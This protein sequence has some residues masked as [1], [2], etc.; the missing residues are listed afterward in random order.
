MTKRSIV[1]GLLGAAF[2]C[3]A[4]YFND[5]VMR[6]TMLIGNSLPVAVYGGL[7]LFLLLVNP[8][9]RRT[10]L[11]R[12]FSGK[13]L[14]VALALTLAA[15]AIPGSGLMRTFTSTLMLPHHFARTEAGWRDQGVMDMTPA[16]MLADVSG[17]DGDTALSGFIQGMGIGGSHIA[18]RDI[19]WQAW[20][21]TLGF[22]LPLLVALWLSLVGLSLV[23]HRQWADHEQ[24]PYP[25]AQFAAAL[26]PESDG[27]VGQVLRAR[28]FWIGAAVVLVIHLINYAAQWFPT[29]VI[30]VQLQFDFNALR[31]IFETV[32]R[33]GGG[34]IFSPQLYLTVVAF[35][36]LLASD[37]S[38][39][40]GLG[41]IVYVYIAGALLGVGISLSGGGYLALKPDTFLNF[42]A[43]FGLFL[44]LVYTGRYFYAG[45]FRQALL[46][47]RAENTPVY[48]VWGARLFMVAFTLLVVSITAIGL[49]WQLAL[50]YAAGLMIILLVM[51]RIIAETGLFFIQ[52]YTF[53]CVV[54]WGIIGTRAMGPQ[55]MLILLLLTSVLLIDPREALMP[56]MVNSLKTLDLK[57]ARI[58]RTAG[59]CVA[60]LLLGLAVAIPVQLYLQYDRG[61]NMADEWASRAV[62][63]MAFD[64]AVRIQQRLS[65]Q[66]TLEAAQAT[67]G[68]ERFAGVSPSPALL[69]AFAVGLAL[70]LLFST[71]R[72]RFPKWPFHP[73]LFLVWNT[74]PARMFAISFLIGSLLKRAVTKY[75]GAGAYRK[76]K[77]LMFGVIAGEMLGGIIPSIIGAVYYWLTGQAPKAFTIMPG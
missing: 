19:P 11:L 67:S 43:Y 30:G 40:L 51:G 38:L 8:V 35:A 12:P 64:E 66:G 50:L 14:A 10:G 2:I 60:A 9:L 16:V 45:V 18:F 22:W 46:F 1:M 7:V 24:L 31:T 13:E 32:D 36:F 47:K 62:P 58:G 68:W 3:A 37:V 4:T 53:P 69:T 26:L 21:P 74:Y 52:P 75:G 6:Q 70:V 49:D 76:L 77:P 23:V 28:P 71:A 33:G 61:A 73:V 17:E 39:S 42:G 54:L 34:F 55:T 48:A 41:P 15:A 72:L 59:W 20:L 65:A 44:M 27:S 25:I 63:R 29:T 57:G 56:F 5:A